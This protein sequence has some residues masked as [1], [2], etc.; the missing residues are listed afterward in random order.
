M[1]TVILGGGIIGL[2]TAYYLSLQR[3]ASESSN[4]AIHIIDSSSELLRSASGY[5]GGFVARDWFA[6]SSASLGSLS[7]KLHREL[8]QQHNGQKLW[9][10]AGSHA[11]SLS[12][13]KY[14]SRA[15]GG[16]ENEDWLTTG[17]SRANV[18]GK[19]SP[20]FISSNSEESEDVF[21]PDGTPR[22]LTPQ[23]NGSLDTISSPSECAQVQPRELCKFL[24][25]ECQSR[26]VQIH[27][28]TN[29]TGIIQSSSGVLT[30]ISLET[31]NE[32]TPKQLPCKDLIICAG[33]W[34][35]TVFCTLF[36]SSPVTV[37]ITPFAGYSLVVKS[38][39]YKTPFLNPSGNTLASGDKEKMCYAFFCSPSPVAGQYTFSP[40]AF[41]R[42]DRG[43]EAEIWIGG[44]NGSNLPLPKTAE[45]VKAQIDRRR[46]KEL[47][48]VLVQLFG[49]TKEGSSLNEDDLE[50]LGEGLCFRPASR[51]GE[52]IL[53]KLTERDLSGVKCDGGGVYIASGHGPWGISLS[54]GTGLV[55][56]EM[57]LG[58]KT[59]VNVSRLG[60]S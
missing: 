7:F 45:Q 32:N 15:T 22:L 52:P 19:S 40:E 34:T 47:R 8:A 55:M 29:P 56:A 28:S 11:Y 50:D 1:S 44:L 49:K 39:R 2:S 3:P 41:A 57:V 5:A 31:A 17:T 23:V 18:V 12:I 10:Y 9:G 21:F 42:L 14:G 16:D 24:L 20:N 46:L 36:P 13:S 60:L 51:S 27:L 26:G 48:G 53:T 25:A 58:K 43:G 38:P 4:P 30:G 59:S 35:P 37:P 6:S 33:A 54:L